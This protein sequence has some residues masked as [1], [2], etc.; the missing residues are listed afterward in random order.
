MV[1]IKNVKL[2]DL[3]GLVK[4]ETVRWKPDLFFQE[5][6]DLMSVRKEKAKD[7]ILDFID[8]C[9]VTK[10]YKKLSM[11]LTL[12]SKIQDQDLFVEI[13]LH[14]FAEDLRDKIITKIKMDQGA[15]QVY[16]L[17]ELLLNIDT[18]KTVNLPCSPVHPSTLRLTLQTL[19]Y[20]REQCSTVCVP[21][22]ATFCDRFPDLFMYNR[23]LLKFLYC[24]YYCK[25]IAPK[26]IIIYFDRIRCTYNKYKKT[27]KF[28][29]VSNCGKYVIYQR[30]RLKKSGYFELHQNGTVNKLSEEDLKW[31]EP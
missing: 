29:V 31:L 3:K 22:Y 20:L 18:S 28:R 1:L 7:L 13:L 11:F 16:V 12:L 23:D 25:R 9:K 30:Q 15:K 4:F 5:I 10:S 24:K 14:C 27:Y 8:L 6:I 19:H 17:E 2:Q 21:S 26:S